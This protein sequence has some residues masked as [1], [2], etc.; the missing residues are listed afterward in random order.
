MVSIEECVTQ[1]SIINFFCVIVGCGLGLGLL[2]RGLWLRPRGLWPRPR[3]LWP[4]PR[5]VVASLI[6]LISSVI[7][8]SLVCHNIPEFVFIAFMHVNKR[9]T[10]TYKDSSS[11]NEQLNA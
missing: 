3:G 11:H 7:S 8:V 4:R 1:P 10:V 9:V 2:S 5:G 6:S